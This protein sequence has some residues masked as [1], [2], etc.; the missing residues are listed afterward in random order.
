M[1]DKVILRLSEK[2]KKGLDEGI[3]KACKD[4]GFECEEFV[5][6]DSVMFYEIGVP[7]R[8]PDSILLIRRGITNHDWFALL[9]DMPDHVLLDLYESFCCLEYR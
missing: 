8:L 2:W 7:E 3:E 6:D 5:R 1:R 4:A 9:N